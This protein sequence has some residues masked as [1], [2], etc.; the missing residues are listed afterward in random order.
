MNSNGVTDTEE[1]VCPLIL[2]RAIDSWLKCSS[3]RYRHMRQLEQLICRVA[4][5][6]V[7]QNGRNGRASKGW[8]LSTIKFLLFPCFTGS[9]AALSPSLLQPAIRGLTPLLPWHLMLFSFVLLPLTVWSKNRTT[10]TLSAINWQ[11][12]IPRKMWGA[13]VGGREPIVLME[14]IGVD[15][16][17]LSWC[18][19]RLTRRDI[20]CFAS[21]T[22]HSTNLLTTNCLWSAATKWRAAAN[23]SLMYNWLCCWS[24]SRH[25]PSSFNRPTG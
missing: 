8:T 3:W 16:H 4:M 11:Q 23:I 6:K 14:P 7:G 24:F 18:M 19:I 1:Y 9:T 5:M 20:W 21:A 10:R 22:N 2:N 13:V 12:L 25:F 15:K 17:R